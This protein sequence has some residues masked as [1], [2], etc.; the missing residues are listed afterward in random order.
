VYS[1]G[2]VGMSRSVSAPCLLTLGGAYSRSAG[3][4]PRW[5]TS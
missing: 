3:P 5:L 1:M 2:A 4:D